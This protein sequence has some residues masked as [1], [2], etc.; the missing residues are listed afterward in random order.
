[1]NSKKYYS[2]FEHFLNIN[3]NLIESF[4]TIKNWLKGYK[5]IVDIGCGIGYL[6]NY[7][8]AIGID[9]SSEAIKQAQK[10]YPKIN[11]SVA[12]VSK[13]LPFDNNSIDAFVC[14]NV[15][16]HLDDKTRNRLYFEFQ[17]CLSKNG[18]IVAAYMNEG[19]WFNRILALIKPDYGS[20]DSSNCVSWTPQEFRNEIGKKFEIVKIKR[21]SQY[22]KMIPFTRFLKGETVIKAKLQQ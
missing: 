10:L 9:N 18:I 6:T 5:T 1:M 7:W 19:Y 16:E 4:L 20:N 13:K 14:Y 17:R 22:G 8:N 11:F 21:T 3:L 12:D 2:R 15:L